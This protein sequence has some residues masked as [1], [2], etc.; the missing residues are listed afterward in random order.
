MKGL[1]DIRACHDDHTCIPNSFGHM[2]QLIS[3]KLQDSFAMFAHN[4][5][6]THKVRFKTITRFNRDKY[7]MSDIT[8]FHYEAGAG[9]EAA[10]HNW[11]AQIFDV[12]WYLPLR[13]S[14]G[15]PAPDW[16]LVHLADPRAPGL[17]GQGRADGAPPPAVARSA[18][19]D[20][21]I[22]ER[23]LAAKSTRGTLAPRGRL[24]GRAGWLA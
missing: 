10:W 20:A 6:N 17:A 24:R 16:P 8:Y 5:A 1:R 2:R 11:F 23:T 7:G 15:A 13:K 14:R 12:N 19:L 4:I 18:S 9:G 3:G 22:Q 21:P